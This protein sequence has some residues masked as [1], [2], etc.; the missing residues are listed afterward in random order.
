MKL[1][2]KYHLMENQKKNTYVHRLHGQSW[3]SLLCDNWNHNITKRQQ[4][5]STSFCH[6]EKCDPFL[7]A[8]TNSTVPCPSDLMFLLFAQFKI[9]CVPPSVQKYWQWYRVTCPEQRMVF[10]VQPIL[11]SA[12]EARTS[13]ITPT[14]FPQSILACDGA[15]VLAHITPL[16]LLVYM[17]YPT[18]CDEWD[19]VPALSSSSGLVW[20]W[21]KICNYSVG[22]VIAGMLLQAWDV[23][24]DFSV[25]LL[26][27]V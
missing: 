17:W 14:C 2:C 13:N 20:L 15:I 3:C 11:L 10:E 6:A 12:C 21:E 4:Y 23:Y 26:L 25:S 27:S 7:A 22:D 1:N 16:G 9:L 18:S 19:H 24:G 5:Q 8:K